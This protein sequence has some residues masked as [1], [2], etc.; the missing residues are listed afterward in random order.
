MPMI[1]AQKLSSV[2]LR[3][4]ILCH[5]VVLNFGAYIAARGLMRRLA[6]LEACL[7]F[8]CQDCKTCSHKLIIGCTHGRRGAGGPLG[9]NTVSRTVASMY[10]KRSANAVRESTQADCFPEPMAS[11]DMCETDDSIKVEQLGRSNTGA[12]AH[13]AHTAT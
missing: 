1:V 6:F 2:H 10:C 11:V 5:F 8:G 12:G 7:H 13:A 4:A 3:S 9:S